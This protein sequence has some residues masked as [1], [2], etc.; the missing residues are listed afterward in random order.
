M[1][2]EVF[3]KISFIGVSLAAMVAFEWSLPGVRLQV[4]VQIRRNSASIVALVTFERLFS[5]VLP[6]HVNY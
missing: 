1:N 5:G 6:H 4:F 2:F 3:C